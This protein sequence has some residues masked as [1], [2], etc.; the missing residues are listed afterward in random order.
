[1]IRVLSVLVAVLFVGACQL[2]EASG[3]AGGQTAPRSAP[4]GERSPLLVEQECV[5]AGG[6]M[7]IGLAG[8]QCAR[9]EP[10]AGKR[11]SDS[12]ECSG[13]CLA[14]TRTC[15]PVT[16]YFGCHEILG[17]GGAPAVIC[18]D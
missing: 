1:M 15:S 10:D 6:Q 11:C 9:P 7:V 2:Q 16:P 14:K 17:A 12:A 3:D 18:V 4:T 13:L 8:P 5:A